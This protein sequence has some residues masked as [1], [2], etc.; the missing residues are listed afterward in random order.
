[1]L[2]FDE[3]IIWKNR[4]IY[5]MFRVFDK[6]FNFRHHTIFRYF[7]VFNFHIGRICIDTVITFPNCS[8]CIHFNALWDILQLH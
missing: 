1:M 5:Y 6:F 7:L 2:W 3:I 8:I 4:I